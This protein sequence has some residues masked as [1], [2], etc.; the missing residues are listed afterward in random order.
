MCACD[1]ICVCLRIC[2]CHFNDKKKKKKISDKKNMKFLKTQ[3]LSLGGFLQ[4]EYPKK[5][6]CYVLK[7]L[8]LY[9]CFK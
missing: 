9:G 3:C 6:S 5:I 7:Y 1:F 4:V 8:I 2:V